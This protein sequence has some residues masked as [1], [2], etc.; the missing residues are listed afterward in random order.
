MN[1]ISGAYKNFKLEA[2]KNSVT[3]P[4]G[5]R[6][7]LALFNMLTGHFDNAT[8]LDGYAGT[9]ALGLEALSR[10]AKKAVFIEKD[11]KA[12]EV[13]KLNA[14]KIQ[15]EKE[16]QILKKD[17]KTYTPDE[18]FDIVFLDPPYDHYDEL[19]FIT[20][21]NYLKTG[22]IL[23]LSHPKTAPAPT[24]DSLKLQSTHTYAMASISLYIK[25]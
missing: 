11:P 20:V 25:Q 21:P 2:P 7:K 15:T 10:G 5:S 8:I 12:I 3:H 19:E 4:M 24:L 17:L 13:I 9:G 1:I 16:I 18:L 6:E 22:G 23:V 14:K